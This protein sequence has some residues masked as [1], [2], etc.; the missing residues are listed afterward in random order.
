MIMKKNKEQKTG[1]ATRRA[2][3]LLEFH[4]DMLERPNRSFYPARGEGYYLEQTINEWNEEDYVKMGYTLD[5]RF[6][7][8]SYNFELITTMNNIYFPD[9]FNLKIKF[10]GFPKIEA[11]YFKSVKSENVKTNS[12]YENIYNEDQA[13]MDKL[14]RIARTVDIVHIKLIYNMD[15]QQ[16]RIKISPY[17][18]A[19]LQLTFPPLFMKLPLKQEEVDALWEAMVLLRK[20]TSK[21]LSKNNF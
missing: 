19:L 9:S 8:K 20:H 1:I 18:G 13:L 11:A 5:K 4:K 6:L 17:A 14:F 10:T 15:Y 16:M 21:E 2:K 7:T 12:V 3:D